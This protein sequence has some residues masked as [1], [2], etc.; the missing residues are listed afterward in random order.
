MAREERA[1]LPLATRRRAVSPPL[2]ARPLFGRGEDRARV[3]SA[4]DA[5][6]RLVTLLG[7]PGIGKTSLARDV[8]A[9]VAGRFADGASVWFVDLS[10][11]RSELDLCFAVLSLLADRS[12]LVASASPAVVAALLEERGP[13]LLV[14]DNFEH[15]AFTAGAIGAWLQASAE[16]VVLVT[17]RE[18]LAIDGEHVIELLPL[19]C[20]REGE[21][22]G[23]L[24]ASEAVQLFQARARDAGARPSSD[25]ASIARIVRRLEGIPL[26]IELAAARTRL[27]SPR[28]LE[29]RLG[30][31]EDVLAAATKRA[32]P[33][34]RTLA[35][36]IEWSWDLL[37]RDEQRALASISVF[38]SSFRVDAA[39]RVIEAVGRPGGGAVE[40]VAALREK[41]LV[42]AVDDDRLGLYLSIREFAARKLEDLGAELVAAAK[43]AHARLYGELARRFNA[44]RL[45][46]NETPE[47]TLHAEAR[48]EREHIVSALAFASTLG[49]P[50]ERAAL[51]LELVAAAAFLF[52]LPSEIA[53]RELEAALREPVIE[54]GDPGGARAT[55][56]LAHQVTLNALGRHD[57]A[58]ELGKRLVD[59]TEAPYGLRCYARVNAGVILRARGKAI[60]A[61]RSHDE[62]AAMLAS[63]TGLRRLVGMNTACMG[64][65][66]CDL[67]HPTKARELNT[68]ATDMCDKLGDRWLAGLGLAN[69]AQLEQE[70][71]CF[72]RA[73][74]LLTR[75]VD[76]FREAGE[77]QYEA[78]YAGIC[79]G[80]HFEWGKHD[81]ARTWYGVA[82]ARLEA[83]V[84]P[85]PRVV[86]H[87]GRAALEATTG[88]HDAA[89]AQ[90]ELARR[91]ALR[92]PGAVAR[93]VLEAHATTVELLLST[94]PSRGVVDPARARVGELLRG[95]SDDAGVV[96]TNL[97]ARFAVRML[98]KTLAA[99]GANGSSGAVLRT[100]QDGLW[101]ALGGGPRVE[102]GRRGALRRI[103]VALAEAHERRS[104][105][106]LDV[107][108]LTSR[109]WPNER[110]LVEA[111]STRVRVAIATLRKLGLRDVLLTRDDGYVID[112]EAVVERA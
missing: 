75:A 18:R 89:R 96:R 94:P 9:S 71:Q 33:R 74:E 34:H 27:L 25:Y 50:V 47:P 57:E 104:G 62:A 15:I 8:A 7:P 90:L 58:L 97:D 61:C 69:L 103:F 64:R 83:L 106:T 20:P 45:L 68:L 48:R 76:R 52:A 98:A 30:R 82:Q 77:P 73:L 108:T 91:H 16:V 112:P 88:A 5:R 11:A 86:V 84:L 13:A 72:E 19:A 1:P 10:N 12:Q 60:E 14:L 66:E 95:D 40:L 32:H 87:A 41:S 42:H 49:A 6:E 63:A 29:A 24:S 44:S 55:V 28:E 110:V 109:G 38:R 79:G 80:L 51:R 78:I 43:L 81:L 92:A 54:A 59:D 4:F 56:L 100:T 46:Q 37:S 105:E 111:A 26:A 99:V 102:L 39:E 35:D 53:D 3:I 70:E 21:D 107:A 93:V 67:S 85:F 17:S 2:P 31:G 65:L 36:A 101:F 22:E 23:E